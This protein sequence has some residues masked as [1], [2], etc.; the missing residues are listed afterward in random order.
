MQIYHIVWL[1]SHPHRSEE[2]LQN[3]LKEGFDIHHIDGNHCN[4]DP[5]NL[6]LIECSDHMRLHGGGFGFVRRLKGSVPRKR[7]RPR[8]GERHRI[9]AEAF[10][11]FGDYMTDEEIKYFRGKIR[12]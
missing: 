9:R 5:N 7:P 3:K 12:N 8:L 10:V 6:V 2:W 11:E 1:T 4:N